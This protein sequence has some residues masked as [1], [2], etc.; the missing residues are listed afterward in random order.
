MGSKF[1]LVG[2]KATIFVNRKTIVGRSEGNYVIPGKLV[3]GK[4]CALIP[5]NNSLFIKDL[6]SDH[7]TFVNGQRLEPNKEYLLKFGDKV[8]F[9][10]TAFML[11]ESEGSGMAANLNAK[12][13]ATIAFFCAIAFIFLKR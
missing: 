12:L 9:G 10:N 3:S 11:K 2:D 1:F 4:H 13:I 5:Q 8:K 6:E 7:G